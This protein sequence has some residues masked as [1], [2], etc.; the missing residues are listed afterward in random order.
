MESRSLPV[1]REACFSGDAVR[2]WSG[3]RS[4]FLLHYGYHLRQAIGWVR[5][6]LYRIESALL[7]TD[8][9][10][11]RKIAGGFPVTR[12]AV[13][14]MLSYA[15]IVFIFAFAR[16]PDYGRQAGTL[17]NEKRYIGIA[18]EPANRCGNRRHHGRDAEHYCYCDLIHLRQS[19]SRSRL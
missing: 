18:A 4:P 10:Y 15:L 19:Q 1:S 5:S 2:A 9:L 17:R 3:L 13:L 11:S 14:F 12:F 8:L 6:P 7:G 16:V